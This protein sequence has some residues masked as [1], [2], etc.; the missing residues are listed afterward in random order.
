MYLIYVYCGWDVLIVINLRY[1]CYF[2]GR[3]LYAPFITVGICRNILFCRFLSSNY[4]HCCS[5]RGQVLA[6][7]S[8]EPC[9]IIVAFVRVAVPHLCTYRCMRFFS[10]RF[11]FSDKNWICKSCGKWYKHKD[12]LRRHTRDECGKM[13]RHQCPICNALFFHRHNLRSHSISKHKLLIW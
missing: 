13:P 11:F 6:N 1:Y 5:T 2:R 10:L 8:R 3:Y 9:N 7:M 12:S 4:R